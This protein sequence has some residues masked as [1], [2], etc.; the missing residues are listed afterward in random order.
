MRRA[1]SS[2]AKDDAI[3]HLGLRLSTTEFLKQHGMRT[4]RALIGVPWTLFPPETMAEIRAQVSAEDHEA[5]RALEVDG[6]LE[7]LRARAS[8]G[9]VSL[10]HR[11]AIETL[12]EDK[13]PEALARLRDGLD[14]GKRGGHAER[15][16][17]I[18]GLV[19]PSAPEV[20]AVLERPKSANVGQVLEALRQRPRK[21]PPAPLGEHFVGWLVP[22]L[23]TRHAWSAAALLA[24]IPTPAA[25]EALVAHTDDT[26]VVGAVLHTLG[27][28]EV[29]RPPVELSAHAIATY[30]ELANKLTQKTAT[31]PF[32]GVV[33]KAACIA[34]LAGA[35][36]SLARA[37]LAFLDRIPATDGGA[38]APLAALVHGSLP[39]LH[40]NELQQV[41][42]LL[43]SSEPGRHPLGAA[44]WARLDVGARLA[45]AERLFRGSRGTDSRLAGAEESAISAMVT[46][47]LSLGEEGDDDAL[48]AFFRSLAASGPPHVRRH[49]L[50][51]P[52]GA[53]P[54][55][56][57]QALR[58][59]TDGG[60]LEAALELAASSGAPLGR[61][62]L[63]KLR[64][65]R[66]QLAPRIL[67]LVEK[68]LVRDDA[69]WIEQEIDGDNPFA[70][71]RAALKGML[72][73]LLR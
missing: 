36:D 50:R 47:L 31:L 38:F 26:S 54:E 4:A 6:L 51:A 22:L 9:Y 57:E 64:E 35:H 44:A 52:G 39:R 68:V 73:R 55:M 3:E 34:S 10:P 63:A 62:V 23:A 37:T 56:I 49:A 18:V 21:L 67:E 46:A 24:R 43:E 48:A 7:S 30:L 72:A 70:D 61:V 58:R 12:P 2:F 33:K 65:P 69:D 32:E 27:R 29:A 19:G 28:A 11:D 16:H 53:T 5:A 42:A 1:L 60:A 13:V 25:V 14:L 59:A 41:A 45:M 20:A 15:L 8:P 17:A 71:R 40:A 66:I